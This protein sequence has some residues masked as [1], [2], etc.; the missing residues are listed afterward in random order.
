LLCTVPRIHR[1]LNH[2]DARALVVC[3]QVRHWH[4]CGYTEVRV[5]LQ[6]T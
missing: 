6:N 1:T 3:R 2:T 5:R 4:W